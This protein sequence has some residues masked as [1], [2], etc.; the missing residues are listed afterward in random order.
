M[1][2]WIYRIVGVLVFIV[3]SVMALG[4]IRYLIYLLAGS[5]FLVDMCLKGLV[6]GLRWLYDFIRR[7]KGLH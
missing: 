3:F 2:I 6:R 7:K 1:E 4:V 5:I